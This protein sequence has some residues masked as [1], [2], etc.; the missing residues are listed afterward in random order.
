MPPRNQANKPMTMR[1]HLDATRPER[2]QNRHHSVAAYTEGITWPPSPPAFF[3]AHAG[4]AT[5]FAFDGTD[6][7]NWKETPG[8]RRPLAPMAYQGHSHRKPEG[9]GD[10]D[11]DAEFGSPHF[12]RWLTHGGASGSQR[13]LGIRIGE[14]SHPG[15]RGQRQDRQTH[16]QN[17]QRSHSHLHTVSLPPPCTLRGPF[18]PSREPRLPLAFPPQ[19][20]PVTCWPSRHG[21]EG[22]SKTRK[23]GLKMVLFTSAWSLPELDHAAPDAL[24]PSIIRVPVFR[25]ALTSRRS[26]LNEVLSAWVP[27]GTHIPKVDAEAWI[28]CLLAALSGCTPHNN[29]RAWTD[30]LFLP[31]LVLRRERG[32]NDMRRMCELWLDG[33]RGSLWWKPGVCKPW[34]KSQS[35]EVA[36]IGWQVLPASRC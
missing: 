22:Q 24:L 8:T 25:T 33:A 32:G 19:V 26:S 2:R 10:D 14:A 34:R 15:P 3:P 16:R 27:L 31:K 13:L 20:C 17:L 21:K 1:A 23:P 5:A 12:L 6:P 30:L 28:R 35:Y 7:I 36:S 11:D 9:S 18:L 29:T 4:R